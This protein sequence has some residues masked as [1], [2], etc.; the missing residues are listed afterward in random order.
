MAHPDLIDCTQCGERH[1]KKDNICPS[2]GIC[3]NMDYND[4][5]VVCDPDAETA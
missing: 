2:C 3:W 1:V 5:C 4:K